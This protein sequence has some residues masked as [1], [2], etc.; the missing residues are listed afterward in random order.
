TDES[1]CHAAIDE[2]ASALGGIDA[3]VYSAGI[4]P[5]VRLPDIDAATWRH[6]L[7]TNL[8]GAALVTSAA[9]P[10]LTESRGAAPYPSSVS[11]ERTPPWPGLAA[12]V[13]SKAALDKLVEAWR[14]EYP[15]VGFTRVIVGDCVGGEGASMVELASSWDPDLATELAP[16]WLQR[17]LLSG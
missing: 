3:L 15:A 5:L 2:A 10:H 14:H 12:Y 11:T 1:S 8:V 16:L 9:L 7:D 17:N 6:T 4:G 13:V